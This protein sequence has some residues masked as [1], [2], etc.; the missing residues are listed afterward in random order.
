MGFGYILNDFIN[1]ETHD[2]IIQDVAHEERQ[3]AVRRDKW[4]TEVHDHEEQQVKMH[5]EQREWDREAKEKADEKGRREEE[6]TCQRESIEWSGLQP[7]RKG[8]MRSEIHPQN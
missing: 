8:R 1:Q 4:N 2:R 6:E 5:Q 7:S 3:R